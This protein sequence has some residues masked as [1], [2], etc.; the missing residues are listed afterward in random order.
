MQGMLGEALQTVQKTQLQLIQLV[1][2][3]PAASS[4]LA[5]RTCGSRP[6]QSCTTSTPALAA[7]GGSAR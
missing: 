5:A 6:Y 4:S 7:R 1:R 2:Q 3:F